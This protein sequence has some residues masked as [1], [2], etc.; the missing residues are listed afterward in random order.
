MPSACG[1]FGV[2]VDSG[3]GRVVSVPSITPNLSGEA[4]LV[5]RA[6]G[7][8]VMVR[9]RGARCPAY[10]AKSAGRGSPSNHSHSTPLGAE[11][12]A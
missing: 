12:R 10:V 3:A 1:P 4:V 2:A 6:V 11:T 7:W 5:L 9:W 8:R